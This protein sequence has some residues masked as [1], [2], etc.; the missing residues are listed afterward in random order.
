MIGYGTVVNH[1]GIAGII[2]DT[3]YRM[4]EAEKTNLHQAGTAFQQPSIYSLHVLG[5]PACP[6]P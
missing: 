4:T 2:Q 1:M 3:I 5:S 6:P